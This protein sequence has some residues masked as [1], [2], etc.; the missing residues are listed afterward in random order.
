MGAV[1]KKILHIKATGIMLLY[2]AAVFCSAL[3][4]AI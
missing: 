3:P 4:T 2:F 1:F